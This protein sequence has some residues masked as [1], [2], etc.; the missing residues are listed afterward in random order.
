MTGYARGGESVLDVR[1]CIQ[2][3]DSGALNMYY[4]AQWSNLH[5]FTLQCGLK[6]ARVF[7]SGLLFPSRNVVIKISSINPRCQ[8]LLVFSAES[9]CAPF[10]SSAVIPLCLESLVGQ[11]N[12]Q[13]F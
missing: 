8:S 11:L 10:L 12:V 5:Q 13:P 3:L 6:I 2:R 1:A 7:L 4:T 9:G